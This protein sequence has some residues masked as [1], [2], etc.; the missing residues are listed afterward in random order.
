MNNLQWQEMYPNLFLVQQDGIGVVYS[1]LLGKFFY[2]NGDG[3]AIIAEYLQLGKPGNHPFHEHLESNGFF[4]TVEPP[5]TAND[6][7]FNSRELTVSMTS[8]C[9][10][11][12]VY[13]YANAGVNF[14]SPTMVCNRK[15]N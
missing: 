1:P 9:N 6:E 11:R 12:C 10:L 13:C 8:A 14:L 3:M 5:R 15:I 4:H 7:W 2:A